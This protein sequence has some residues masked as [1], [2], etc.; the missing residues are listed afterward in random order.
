[1]IHLTAVDE[2]LLSPACQAPGFDFIVWYCSEPDIFRDRFS[3]V[4]VRV[5]W[6]GN[7]C[8]FQPGHLIWANWPG[9]SPRISY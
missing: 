8:Y 6:P 2:V 1:M 9:Q 3:P 7:G 5:T 4:H